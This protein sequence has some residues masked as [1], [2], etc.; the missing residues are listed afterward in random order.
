MRQEAV[1]TVRSLI[2]GIV[3]RPHGSKGF[4]I[5]LQ[6]QIAAMA[7]LGHD[8]TSDAAAVHDALKS[9]VKVLSPRR[10]KPSNTECGKTCRR[11][12]PRLTG[13]FAERN[14]GTSPAPSSRHPIRYGGR[15]EISHVRGTSVVFGDSV[16]SKLH[17]TAIGCSPRMATTA[18]QAAARPGHRAGNALQ[19]LYSRKEPT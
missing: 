16:S 14:G 12:T 10:S 19:R 18:L 7:A 1:E 11:P 8:K 5:E 17:G 15:R 2:D 4:E 6:G 13:H 9:S 3:M